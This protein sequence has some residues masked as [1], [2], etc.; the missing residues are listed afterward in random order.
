MMTS[1]EI[2]SLLV[3]IGNVK[4]VILTDGSEDVCEAEIIHGIEGK[5]VIEKLLFFIIAAKKSVALI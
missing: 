5:E 3:A 4:R 2:H 1:E